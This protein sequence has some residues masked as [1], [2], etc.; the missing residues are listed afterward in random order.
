MVE[1]A[2]K[3]SRRFRHMIIPKTLAAKIEEYG[4]PQVLKVIRAWERRR[5]R[6][7]TRYLQRQAILKSILK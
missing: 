1:S 5:D 3:E 7:K 6:D 4:A 2:W